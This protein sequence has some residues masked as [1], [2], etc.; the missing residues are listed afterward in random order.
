[1]LS[2]G[3]VRLEPLGPGHV[4]DLVAAAGEDRSLYTHTF[5]PADRP[6][7]A[8]Y[9]AAAGR[10][11][12]RGVSLAF[13]TVRVADGR[14]VGST[15]FC[16]IEWWDWPAGHPFAGRTTPDAVEIGN[17][18]LAASAVRT[19]CNTEAKLLMLG[20]AFERWAVHRVRFRTDRR[21]ARS[22]AAIERLGA[23]HDGILRGDRT[24]ADGSVRD[25]AYFSIVLGEWPA[26]AAGLRARLDAG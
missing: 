6:A 19:G 26:V 1:M 5:V 15:R 20:H 9:V 16:F 18:W 8:A 13:A 11:R 4:D 3:I 21:N 7:M 10:E 23:R 12:E 14:A 17:T 22:W 25:S 2:G 24:G